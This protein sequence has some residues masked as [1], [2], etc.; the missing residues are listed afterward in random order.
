MD[1]CK[2]E[3]TSLVD[4]QLHVISKYNRMAKSGL[5]NSWSLGK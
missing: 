1:N 5:F 4:N 2:Q 3:L